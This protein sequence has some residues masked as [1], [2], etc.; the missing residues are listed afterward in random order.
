MTERTLINAML[1]IQ[2]LN[3]LVL[4]GVILVIRRR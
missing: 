3:S 1:A 4:L 2:L